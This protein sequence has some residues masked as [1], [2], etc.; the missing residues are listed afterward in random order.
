[1]AV[2]MVAGPMTLPKQGRYLPVC[3]ETPY[4]DIEIDVYGDFNADNDPKLEDLNAQA[5]EA[6]S[7]ITIANDPELPEISF[8]Q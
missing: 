8:C 4:A 7:G 5:Y 3:R 1:M 2:A 6:S